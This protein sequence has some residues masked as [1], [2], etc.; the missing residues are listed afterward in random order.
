MVLTGVGCVSQSTGV[1][2]LDP[3]YTVRF[4]LRSRWDSCTKINFRNPLT[5]VTSRV[6][7]SQAKEKESATIPPLQTELSAGL[8]GLCKQQDYNRFLPKVQA[9]LNKKGVRG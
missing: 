5:Y 3:L 1:W 4:S 2:L 8:C 9:L 6:S 7:I